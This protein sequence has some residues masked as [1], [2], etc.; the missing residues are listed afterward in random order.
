MQMDL[1]A[2]ALSNIKN[3]DRIGKKECEVRHS[4]LIENVLSVMKKYGYIKD[5]LLVKEGKFLKIKVYLLNKIVDCNAIK[6]RFSCK[7]EEFL[8]F[9][10]RFLPAVGKGII[11][12]ST[13]KGVISHIEARNFNVGGTLLAYVY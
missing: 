6:P 8:K 2:D 3:C 12:L 7:V 5:Y 9:E 10:K 11:I 1:L 4:K 13:N